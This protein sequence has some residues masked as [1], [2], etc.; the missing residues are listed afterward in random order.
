MLCNG[1]GSGMA[2]RAR[3]G[4][5][6]GFTEPVRAPQGHPGTRLVIEVKERR[7]KERK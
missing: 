3:V 6:H 7:Y 1:F 2:G 4:H 5:C